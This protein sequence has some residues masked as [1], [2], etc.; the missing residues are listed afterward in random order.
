[1]RIIGLPVRVHFSHQ[2]PA[3]FVNRQGGVNRK[4]HRNQFIAHGDP[5]FGTGGRRLFPEPAGLSETMLLIA[6]V[7]IGRI[8]LDHL[9]LEHRLRKSVPVLHRG[10]T[11]AGGIE[12]VPVSHIQL[13]MVHRGSQP[14]FPGF[15]QRRL[16]DVRGRAKK[17][18]PAGAA[19]GDVTDPGA[20]FPGFE[21][22]PVGALPKTD[23][24]H[25][26]R[27]RDRVLFTPAL[28]ADDPVKS[29]ETAR[30][31]NGG[32]PMGQPQLCRIFRRHALRVST[33]V[34]MHVHEAGQQEISLQFHD[35]VAFLRLRPPVLL[36]RHTGKSDIV[37]QSNVIT[38]D[39][40][41]HGSDRGGSLAVHHGHSS[42]YQSLEWPFTTLPVW[43]DIRRTQGRQ[44]DQKQ[45]QNKQWLDYFLHNMSR[46]H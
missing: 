15:I 6:V 38:L 37:Y 16:H 22:W 46:A 4:L 5:F 39:H 42:Q 31:T 26:A 20:C 45:D 1:M 29:I 32:N 41:I 12:D 13:C 24:R 9:V 23:I 3:G 8:I 21:E 34:R 30:L 10:Q 17:L 2:V 44:T 40:D 11:G 27:R 28:M 14:H 36:Y 19:L 18:D 35:A 33:E 25:D 43:R 7:V